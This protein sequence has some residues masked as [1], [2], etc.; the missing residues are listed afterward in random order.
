MAHRIY[1]FKEGTKYNTWDEIIAAGDIVTV[2]EFDT[3]DEA[4]LLRGKKSG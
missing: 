4:R 1:T 2:E 3:Y